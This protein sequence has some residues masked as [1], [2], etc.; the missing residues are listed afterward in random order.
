MCIPFLECAFHF[1]N[2]HSIPGMCIP[3]LECEQ[4]SRQEYMQANALH[5]NACIKITNAGVT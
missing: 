3:F 1:W 2:V 5:V 4:L